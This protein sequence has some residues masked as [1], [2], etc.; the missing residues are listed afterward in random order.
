M[1][2]PF[3]I[4]LIVGL[5]LTGVGVV[6]NAVTDV[7]SSLARPKIMNLA[8]Q[9]SKAMSEN[10][11]LRERLMHAYET[12]NSGLIRSA[13]S[14][15]GFGSALTSLRK[16]ISNLNQQADKA[17][18]ALLKQRHELENQSMQVQD[19]YNQATSGNLVQ[20]AIALGTVHTKGDQLLNKIETSS[21]SPF[22]TK[23]KFG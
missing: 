7:L 22:G 17:N 8:R 11:Q 6:S 15:N 9:V 12:K 18:A 2:E 14:A 5:V 21:R 1:P 3:T 19:L 13:L 4:S 10:S 16:D 20:S 23:S